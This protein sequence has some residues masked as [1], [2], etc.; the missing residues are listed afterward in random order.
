MPPPLPL[1]LLWSLLLLPS[2]LLLNMVTWSLPS[3][4]RWRLPPVTADVPPTCTS[5]PPT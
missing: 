1:L 2:S 4:A 5:W 3:L